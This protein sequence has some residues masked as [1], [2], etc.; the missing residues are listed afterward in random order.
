MEQRGWA[1]SR[2]H[3]ASSERVYKHI[4]IIQGRMDGL[5]TCSFPLNNKK[6]RISQ[7]W[8]VNCLSSQASLV[9]V[10]SVDNVT[11]TAP[12]WS[13][14]LLFAHLLFLLHF[15]LLFNDKLK[16]FERV[17]HAPYLW[18]GFGLS[19]PQDLTDLLQKTQRKDFSL[20]V[21]YLCCESVRHRFHLH[22]HLHT[23]LF[24]DTELIQGEKIPIQ[25]IRNEC[26]FIVKTERRNP[27]T[28]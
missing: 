7:R 16:P 3:S 25:M 21:L 5:E 2:N 6:S 14:I 17:V 23:A 20:S 11:I 24:K 8:L 28:F 27:K 19:R 13:L 10:A 9:V 1:A 26:V 4:N 15:I 18:L 12:L 22:K